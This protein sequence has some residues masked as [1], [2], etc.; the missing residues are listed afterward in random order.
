MQRRE[1]DLRIRDMELQ[2]SLIKFSN[3]LQENEKKRSM[4]DKKAREEAKIASRV[5]GQVASLADEIR[6]LESK[7]EEVTLQLKTEML[8][9][10]S[11]L[12]KTLEEADEFQETKEISSRFENL[13]STNKQL[14]EQNDALSARYRE[15]SRGLKDYNK[16]K[17]NEIQTQRNR[18]ATLKKEL[19][20]MEAITRDKELHNDANLRGLS[21]AMLMNG[22]VCLAT[23][24][25]YNRCCKKSCMSHPVD[26]ANP[27]HQ[28][29][30][31]GFFVSDYGSIIKEWRKNHES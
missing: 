19:E 11:F 2:D 3:F 25:L 6:L 5:S 23:N 22:Q 14:L 15:L 20:E 13:Q 1:E 17:T 29:E 28:L 30:V 4:L 18:I 21:Q 10:M 8:A 31:V 26:E 9:Y 16:N 12:E 27:L 24:N 7:K